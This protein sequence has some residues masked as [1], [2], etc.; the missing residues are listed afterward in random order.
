M[1]KRTLLTTV[2]MM[3]APQY[4]KTGKTGYDDDYKR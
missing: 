1:V 4:A 2:I 3:D